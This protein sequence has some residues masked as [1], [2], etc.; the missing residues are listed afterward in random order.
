M[1]HNDEVTVV[2]DRNDI[3]PWQVGPS[4]SARY[5][6]GPPNGPDHGVLYVTVE[7]VG[8]IMINP[9]SSAFIGIFPR[10]ANQ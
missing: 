5:S 2:M 1:H 3:F 9:H 10:K 7:P 6:Y 8:E 4:F